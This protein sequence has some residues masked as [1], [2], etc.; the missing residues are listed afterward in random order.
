M[1]KISPQVNDTLLKSLKP[2]EN[3]YFISDGENMLIEI[4]PNGK[5]SFILEYKSPATNK[6]ARITLGQYP[7]MSLKEARALK[8][9]LKEQISKGIDPKKNNTDEG[10]RFKDIFHEWFMRKQKQVLAKQQKTIKSFF[11]RF[12]LPKFGD[13]DIKKISR[14]D[15]V[16]ALEF[17]EFEK[18]YIAFSKALGAMKEL[19]K[20]AVLKEYVEHNIILDIDKKALFKAPETRHYAA[21]TDEQALAHLLNNIIYYSG[22]VRV[23]A[24]LVL[25]IM[26]AVRPFNARS[27]KWSEFDLD[28]GL[29]RIPAEQMKMKRPHVVFLSDDLCKFLK[30][31]RGAFKSEYLFPSVRSLTR[32]ISDNAC[33]C[34][35]R[36][37]GYSNEEITPH[38]FR[39]TFSTIC[40]EKRAEHKQNS[41]IIELCLAHIE[42]NKVK[43][44]YN[45]AKNL[46]ERKELMLWWQGFI[47]ALCPDIYSFIEARSQ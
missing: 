7:I 8:L 2:K 38:G 6:M 14:R 5:K 44:A 35:L 22:D 12:F 45:H 39:A 27:A 3:K 29:W 46:K 34:S 21:I 13:M 36:N 19:Y 37:M 1:P 15:I 25:S 10:K 26:T 16:S 9:E 31:Y 24:C 33:R 23:K 47:Y 28:N 18:K 42:T 4:R 41:D 17:L 40:H 30:S 20:Y 43:D 11:D 32:P